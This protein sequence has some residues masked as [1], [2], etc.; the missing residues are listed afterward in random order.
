MGISKLLI[1]VM[2]GKLRGEEYMII[3]F[4]KYIKLRYYSHIISFHKAKV[5]MIKRI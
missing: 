1:C 3:R 5:Y 4:L 2:H